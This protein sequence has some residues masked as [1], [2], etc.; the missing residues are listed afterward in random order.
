MLFDCCGCCPVCFCT[1][2][3]QEEKCLVLPPEQLQEGVGGQ[4]SSLFAD[5]YDDFFS[6]FFVNADAFIENPNNFSVSK[7]LLSVSPAQ[8]AECV[9]HCNYF[10]QYLV[11]VLV[12]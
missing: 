9:E 8:R 12:C 3:T 5:E 7:F 11:K 4:L 6:I 10:V 1:K 2:N